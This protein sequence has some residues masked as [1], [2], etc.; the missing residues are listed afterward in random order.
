MHESQLGESGDQ[1]V[2]DAMLS[3][4]PLPLRVPPTRTEGARLPVTAAGAEPEMAS[5]FES[6]LF[7]VGGALI[8]FLPAESSVEKSSA[9]GE[10]TAS[11]PFLA[12]VEN[13]F[14]R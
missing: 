5:S 3:V 2:G 11:G 4:G 12:A 9:Y 1:L 7:V 10:G 14:G 13:L 8:D 6:P